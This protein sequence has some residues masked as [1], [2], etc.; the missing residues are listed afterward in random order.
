MQ[1]SGKAHAQQAQCPVCN[2]QYLNEK[3][4]KKRKHTHTLNICI[5]KP[6]KQLFDKSDTQGHIVRT[7]FFPFKIVIQVNT[8]H[9][10]S[11]FITGDVYFLFEVKSLDRNAILT[12]VQFWEDI[13]LYK[14]YNVVKSRDHL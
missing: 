2:P 12:T 10:F 4:K 13:S 11:N 5:F 14:E 7:Q 6:L 8:I 9:L 3:K 1:L